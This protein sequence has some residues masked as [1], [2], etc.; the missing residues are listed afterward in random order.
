MTTNLQAIKDELTNNPVSLPYLAVDP[1][2]AV[3]NA[4]VINNTDGANPRTIN[5]VN[6]ETGDIRAQTTRVAFDGLVAAEESWLRWLTAS[7]TIPVTDDTL[8]ELAGIPTA[9]DSIWA[10]ADR[11]LMNARITA[12]MQR[13]GSRAEEISDLLGTSSPTPAEVRDASNLP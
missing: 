8:Q 2:N 6:V 10:V 7:G 4:N 5:N 9:N 11:T 1:A 13:T 3:A 12:L